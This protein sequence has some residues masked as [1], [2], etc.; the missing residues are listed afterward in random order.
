MRVLNLWQK[1]EVFSSDVVQ[2]LLDLA[3]DPTNPSNI[4]T[5]KA[6]SQAHTFLAH[7]SRRLT[8]ELIG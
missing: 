4:A 3:A 1:N 7:L 5:G 8:G 6:P 2:P